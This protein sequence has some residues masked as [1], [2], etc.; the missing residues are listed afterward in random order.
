MQGGR[1]SFE[2]LVSL[3]RAAS[4]TSGGGSA[5][6][7]NSCCNRGTA[8]PLFI[9]LPRSNSARPHGRH[10]EPWAADS[11][12]TDIRRDRRSESQVGPLCA[13]FDECRYNRHSAL[14]GTRIWHP[15]HRGR[16]GVLSIEGAAK[17]H[18]EGCQLGLQRSTCLV[19]LGRSIPQMQLEVNLQGV[20]VFGP[21]QTR[22]P[23]TFASES[24][25]CR[26]VTR[27]GHLQISAGP[28]TDEQRQACARH[29]CH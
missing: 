22:P 3:G 18:G 27:S 26:I 7:C 10:P 16:L 15:R 8:D 20:T 5:R 17:R 6:G 2:G 19:G 21:P 9:T 23:Q 11:C 4:K 13:N 14:R 12:C 29:A 28:P 1:E 25:P 24:E